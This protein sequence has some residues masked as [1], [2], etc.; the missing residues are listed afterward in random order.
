MNDRRDPASQASRGTPLAL[1][2]PETVE[3]KA[4]KRKPQSSKPTHPGHAKVVA[5]YFETFEQKRG[6]KP[7]FD[8][9]DGKTI[10]KLLEKYADPD[11]V[12]RIISNAFEG[13]TGPT[14]TIRRIGLDPDQFVS[15]QPVRRQGGGHT[16]PS[17]GVLKAETYGGAE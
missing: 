11:K 9:R 3:P 13:F 12:C 4:R 6:T 14:M 10:G 2:P 17:A 8:G 16:Q 5:H 1:T 7:S 15:P